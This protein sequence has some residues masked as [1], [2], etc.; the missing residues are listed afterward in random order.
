MYKL[1][2]LLICVFLLGCGDHIQS[3]PCDLAKYPWVNTFTIGGADFS[4]I[5][6]NLDTGHYE[7]S[8]RSKYSARDYF[9]MVDV[10]AREDNWIL[11][12]GDAR[13]KKFER[14]ST[15]FPAAKG[16]DIVSIEYKDGGE[17]VLE[18]QPNREGVRDVSERRDK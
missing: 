18:F 8:F 2:M 10:S 9:P 3:D 16:K 5:K 13:S 17:I 15:I 12:G 7:F 1:L 6:H 4:R 14:P 11:V